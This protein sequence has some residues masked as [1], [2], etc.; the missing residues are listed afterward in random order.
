MASAGWVSQEEGGGRGKEGNN[1]TITLMREQKW[2][3]LGE[4]LKMATTQAKY[5]GAC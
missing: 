5:M 3:P 4:K 1:V 2:V